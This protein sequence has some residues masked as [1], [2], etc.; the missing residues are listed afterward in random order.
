MELRDLE[1]TAN[2]LANHL[3]SCGVGLDTVVALALERSPRFVAAA[4]AI[5][6]CGATYLPMNLRI[7]GTIGFMWSIQRSFLL[8][9]EGQFADRLKTSIAF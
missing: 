2:R 8:S 9:A 6:K 3:R 5:M 7:D 4:L 1:S